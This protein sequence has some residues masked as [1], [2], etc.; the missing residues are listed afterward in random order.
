MGTKLPWDQEWIIESLSDST[1]YMAYY[2]ISKHIKKHEI[3]PAQLTDEVFD[4]V[5]L[6]TGKPDEVAV[7]ADIDFK[8]LE[9][10][11]RD[12]LYFYPLDSRHSGRDLVPNHLTF[13]IFNHT[14]IFPKELWPRQ[15]VTNGSV[16]MQGAKMSKS[17][18]NIIPLIEGIAQFGADPLRMGILATAELLQDAD[19]SPTLAKSM[20]DRLERL[21]RFGEEIAKNG[22]PKEPKTLALPDRW[23]LSRLQK[24]IRMAT[25]A[26]DKLAVRKAIHSGLYELD[27]D[28]QWYLRRTAD[29]MS[30]PSRKEAVNYVLGQ[31]IDAQVKMLAPV[32]PHVC[33]E[34]WAKRGGKGFVALAS[35]PEPNSDKVDVKAE[36][37]ETLIESAIE[38]TQNIIKATSMT[39]KI[40]YYYVA[41][42]WKWKAYLAALK[43]SVSAKLVQGE[44][45]KELMTDPLMKKEARS[46]AK[47]VGQITEEVNRMSP[48][49]RQRQLQASDVDETAILN[50]AEKFLRRE[51]NAEIHIYSEDDP[52]R[53][54]P[55]NRAQIAK[56]YRPAIYVE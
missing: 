28:V 55:K 23:M 18:G 13:L 24:H 25:E 27:Q 2:T 54:D 3:K 45:I 22:N 52:K 30:V 21:Y 46:V 5:F 56:P 35:W 37:S 33:E 1:I 7:K 11:R 44:L 51:L 49:K 31:V 41:A 29:Q 14:A 4:Y 39:P 10:M 15:I 17:F 48:E 19:F 20:Q 38:D 16:T 8:V 34:L 47:L 53:H 50:D 40:I 6:G 43:K 9:D 12:F 42:A 26:M 32:T 36:E